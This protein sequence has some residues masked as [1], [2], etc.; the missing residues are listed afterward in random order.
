[1]EIPTSQGLAAADKVETVLFLRWIT[2]PKFGSF[3]ASEVTI[4]WRYRKSIIIIV[5]V[6]KWYKHTKLGP[7]S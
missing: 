2:L 7:L 6:V 4:I 1:V 3:S 5:V